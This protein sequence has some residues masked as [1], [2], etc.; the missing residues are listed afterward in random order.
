MGDNLN[1]D[2]DASRGDVKI[3]EEHA[4]ERTSQNFN[5]TS[6]VNTRLANPLRPVILLLTY[7]GW[8]DSLQM[9]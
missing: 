3:T 8:Q 2:K 4:V 7:L 5:V 9:N 6:N 1:A